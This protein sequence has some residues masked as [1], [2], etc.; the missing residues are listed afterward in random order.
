MRCIALRHVD[1]EVLGP[2]AGAD[3]DGRRCV[4]D[5]DNVRSRLAH[6]RLV[7]ERSKPA[8]ADTTQSAPYSTS[9]PVLHARGRFMPAMRQVWAT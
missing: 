2:K 7:G 1:F 6:S 8:A 9:Q 3:A 5:L 4:A